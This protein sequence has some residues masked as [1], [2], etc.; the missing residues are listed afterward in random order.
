MSYLCRW[1]RGGWCVLLTGVT[2]AP[3]IGWCEPKVRAEPKLLSVYPFGGSV[4]TELK[5]KVRGTALEGAYGVWFDSDD[6]TATVQRVDVV[7][8]PSEDE[9][10]SYAKKK[11][12]K[13]PKHGAVLAVRISDTAEPGVHRMRLVTPQGVSDSLVFRV[14]R[15]PA[16]EE[17]EQD[18]SNADAP[19][20][21][22]ERPIAV[23]GRIAAKGEVDYYQF[24]A[25][26]GEELLFE[27]YA[28]TAA[29]DPTVTL[30][31]P[32]GS[33]LNPERLTRLAYNNE[34][35]HFPGYSNESRLTYRFDKA[36]RYLLRVESFLGAGS[37]DHVY[38]L[39]VSPVDSAAPKTHR[40]RFRPAQTLTNRWEERDFAREL[41]PDHMEVLWSRSVE[42]AAAEGAD[43][44]AQDETK[45]TNPVFRGMIP[46]T[47]VD[48]GAEP[49]EVTVPAM[50]EGAIERAGDT[51]RVRFEAKRGD[52]V[53]LE[54]QTTEATVPDFN[55]FLKVVDENGVEVFTNIHSNLNNNGGFIMKTVQ[56]KTTFTFL[57]D[58]TFTLEIRDITTQLADDRFGYRVL[59]RPQ[60]PHVG[61]V[62]IAEDHL[63]LNPGE[64]KKI[65]I[66]TDQEEGFDGY[67][68]LAAEGLPQGVRTMMATEVIPKKPPPLNDGKK[69]RYVAKNHV[70][71][72]L[73]MADADAPTTMMPSKVKIK[74][75]PVR[76]GRMGNAVE[77]KELL[78]MVRRPTTTINQAGSAQAQAAR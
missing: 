31:A 72:L 51:D 78:V 44:D 70:A 71:T 46:V 3:H 18:H 77:V 26:A 65:S 2:L 63:N 45:K 54:I 8:E 52:R 35:V 29:M 10:K 4:G 39:R 38:Q 76:A 40:T 15:Q 59:L 32:T 64:V 50:I 67:I 14:H 17:T 33:W 66:I 27:V 22:K 56:P 7:A 48:P 30:F 58:G 61:A 47:R 55:P 16:I 23:N 6:L 36:G 41:P 20:W 42:P 5:A 11:G 12:K 57:R 37:A 73:V 21:L 49:V 74:A 25:D 9:K 68:G 24:E 53:V 69:H 75:T 19:Q 28:G 60:V 1:A 43:D 13:E 62:H 34:P